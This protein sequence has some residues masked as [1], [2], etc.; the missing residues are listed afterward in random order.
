MLYAVLNINTLGEDEFKKYYSL[1]P[2]ERKA[3]CDRFSSVKDK[4]LC[5]GAYMLLCQIT[6]NDKIT[7][8]YSK[9]G[10]PYIKDSPVYFSLSHSGNYAAAAVSDFP[11]GIDI[12]TVGEIKDSVIKRVCSN[13]ERAYINKTSRDSF[14]KI[15]TYKEAYLKMTGDGIGAG[16]KTIDYTKRDENVISVTEHGYAMCVIT[17]SKI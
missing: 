3:E 14:Y 5:V 7:F 4:K 15:W 11:V 16:L 13:E 8:C 9:T 17:E 12:E 10:K 6:G 2:E 1:M